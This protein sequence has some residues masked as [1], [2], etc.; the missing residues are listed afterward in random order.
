MKALDIS[1][2]NR[3]IWYSF[4]RAIEPHN[5]NLHMCSPYIYNGNLIKTCGTRLTKEKTEI[6]RQ[7]V[8]FLKWIGENLLI[9]LLKLP[10]SSHTKLTLKNLKNREAHTELELWGICCIPKP[11]AMSP[12]TI[13]PERGSDELS[14]DPSHSPIAP[15]LGA[16]QPSQ[17]PS[18]SH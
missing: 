11:G 16:P 10:Q 15:S 4:S 14:F 5:Q 8:K 3:V 12:L 2:N 7:R 6:L 13:V 1:A 18:L 17:P 9:I